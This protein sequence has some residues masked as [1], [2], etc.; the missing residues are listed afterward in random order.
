LAAGIINYMDRSAVSIAAPE[1]IKT[2]GMTRTDIG[3][4]GTVF[5]WTYAF[6]QLPAGWLVDKLG[7]RRMYFLAIACWSIATALMA[8]GSRLWQFLSFRVLLGIA[9]APNGPAS[10]KLTADWFP[11][12]ERGQATA[13]WDS[14]SK[15]GPA[16]A[17]PILTAIMIAFGWQAI[18]VVLG[19]AG[20]VLAV[21]FFLFYRSPEAHRR[22]SSEELDYIERERASQK[23]Q[24]GK[25]SWLG[26]FRHRQIWGMMAGFFCVIWIWNI[27]IVFLP[28]YLQEARGVSIS[29]SGWLAAI[30]YLGAAILG[31]TGGWVMTRHS[32]RSGRNPLMAKRHVMSVAAVVAGVLICLIPFVDSLPLTITVMTVALGF[33]ATMQA[34]AWAMPGDVVQN[35]QVASV[36]AIQNFGGYF[37]GAFAP[38]LTGVIADATGS[39]TMSFVIGGIIAAMA[40]VAYTVLVRRPIAGAGV[41]PATADNTGGR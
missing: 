3:L 38:L 8:F 17:P 25:T 30:P 34:A 1:L 6:A 22:I 16:I 23:L 20:L 10:A 29:G 13:I 11:R 14:G 15:W 12:T 28:L 24:A 32:R 26:L 33:V 39:Y 41:S 40:A 7:A 35:S 4:L 27:F 36:G 9:E 21:A 19:L 37:G 5:S 2:F 18:F 31:I